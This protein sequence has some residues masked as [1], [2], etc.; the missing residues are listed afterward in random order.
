MLPIKLPT[1]GEAKV[2]FTL[3]TSPKF[4]VYGDLYS[5]RRLFLHLDLIEDKMTPSLMKEGINAIASI[6][7]AAKE[8]G[9]E[10][11]NVLVP[12]ELVKFENIWGFSVVNVYMADGDFTLVHLMQ[13]TN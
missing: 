13:D 12:E 7:E 6:K 9:I 4:T 8:A 3:Y 2:R 1:V 11:L 5:N 10:Y